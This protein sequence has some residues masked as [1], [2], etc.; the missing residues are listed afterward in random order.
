MN[1]LPPLGAERYKFVV[2]TN[3]LEYQTIY[4]N[5]FYN[6]DNYVWAKLQADN[7]DKV[8]VG[9]S[10]IL[11]LGGNVVATQPIKIKVLAI[12]VFEKDFISGNLDQNGN[13]I[14]ESSG[15]Y[16]Q[17]RP[18]GFSMD[19][20]DYR[21]YQNQTGDR[22]SSGIPYCYLDLFTTLPSTELEIGQGSSIYIMINSSR[23]YNA[24]WVDIRYENTFFAQRN[25]ATLEEWFDENL[26]NGNFIP[27]IDLTTGD[28]IN[29][30]GNLELVR[31]TLSSVGIGNIQVFT[32]SVSGKLYLR[33]KGLLEGGSN[34][35]S[36]YC[37]AEIV[38]RNSTGIY[39]FETDPK[40]VDSTTF[41]ESEETFDIVNGEHHGSSQYPII[42]NQN[43]TTLQP[44]IIDLSF[45][46]CF[47]MGNGVESY[48][49]RD[50]FNTNSLNIDLRPTRTSVEPYRQ[51][52]KFADVTHSSEPYNESSNINGLNNF[53][54][55]T[56]NF[57]ELDK[58]YG[59]IQLIHNKENDILVIQEEKAG[60]I[61]FGKEV[62]YTAE[63]EPITTE[64]SQILGRYDPYQ[65]NNGI[66]LNPESFAYDNF[67][68]Y[69][70]NSYFGV[71][72]RLSID[73]TTEINS[74]MVSYFRNIA[75][76][77]RKALKIGGF[78]KFNERYT[79]SIGD[80]P[81]RLNYFDCG[82]V[83]EREITEEFS[84]IL[85]LNNQIGEVTLDYN[86]TGDVNITT[87]F[88]GTTVVNENLTGVGSIVINRD[89]LED[90]QIV[91]TITPNQTSYIIITN[92]CPL[93]VPL[94]IVLVVVGD[95]GDAGKT[96][97]NRFRTNLNTFLECEDTF[98]EGPITKMQTINGF[99]GQSL[100]PNNGD[101]ITIQS[102]KKQ[103][104]TASFLE[105]EQCNKIKYLISDQVY[106]SLEINELLDNSTNLVLTETIQGV[107]QNTFTGS[108]EFNRVAL[109]E[110]LYL[111]WD[112]KDKK[113]VV[114]D[115]YIEVLTNQTI[116][117][118]VI[119]SLLESPTLTIDTDVSEG[120]LTINLDN[121]VTYENLSGVPGNDSA[122]LY[123]EVDGCGTLF[124]LF[125]TIF[126]ESEPPSLFNY[127]SGK[128][129]LSTSFD[130][131][132]NSSPRNIY[133]DVQPNS[134]DD[135][136]FDVTVIY[137]NAAGTILAPA[138]WYTDEILTFSP[139]GFNYIYWNGSAVVS[140]N[141]GTCT[142]I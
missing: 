103:I 59:S 2:K 77:N 124:N 16:M 141:Q 60:K 46:N 112:Y 58:Q 23:N 86:I 31:G 109:N 92:I 133:V 128:R 13:A 95:V 121:T 29:Y 56:A 132:G 65:G 14:I 37:R 53:N 136:L 125:I 140:A 39:V 64:I 130:C 27:G 22:A 67:R 98:S 69:W 73:G 36:G 49:V 33:V 94:D 142:T 1:S 71:P 139:D 111:I 12:K 85:N 74:G 76:S 40:Q 96:I 25:Y 57:K 28:S 7:K 70:F 15:T 108:F 137:S 26:L 117:F 61:L 91:I 83:L 8:K 3:P 9:D 113:P 78:D 63:G 115:V 52:R 107:N 99:E 21:I 34:G 105:V 131:N 38:V 84:Y 101:T 4:I 18:N 68:F 19:L 51:V 43:N 82:N 20:D 54:L 80:E 62:I 118:S 104:H 110:I 102:V 50:E 90:N 24:G 97:L 89:S 41:F 75:I 47:T 11:K 6:E 122:V 135:W 88:N 126:D 32:P 81:I 45:F 127:T 129:N 5:E 48:R 55:A 10:L 44:A 42:Q 114:S 35:R 66:G 17:I 116:T 106:T 30:A 120:T 72:I 119:D 87:L 123:V 138:G 134:S 100:F 79:L 93:P